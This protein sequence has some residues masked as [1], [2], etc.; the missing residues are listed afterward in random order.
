MDL[1]NFDPI[2]YIVLLNHMSQPPILIGSTNTTDRHSDQATL[3][4]CSNELHICTTCMWCG[5]KISLYVVCGRRKLLL[6]VQHLLCRSKVC[7]KMKTFGQKS[8]ESSLRIC[9]KILLIALI[10]WL[11]ML[12][13]QHS[14]L[15]YVRCYSYSMLSVVYVVL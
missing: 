11:R 2:L 9:V 4:I 3:D 14:C 10:K 1:S 12:S 5:I 13:L 7:L 8:Q 6:I 15:W